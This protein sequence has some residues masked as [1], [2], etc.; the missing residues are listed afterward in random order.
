MKLSREKM[1]VER[2]FNVYL[3]TW[4]QDASYLVDLCRQSIVFD[5][6]AGITACLHSIAEDPE[7]EVSTPQLTFLLGLLC[8][9]NLVREITSGSSN[10]R[11]PWMFACSSKCPRIKILIKKKSNVSAL[12]HHHVYYLCRKFNTFGFISQV[13]RVKNRFDPSYDPDQSQG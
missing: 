9:F 2:E 11:V 3:F 5:D 6:L 7:V 8:V 4:C 10:L 13:V 12:I 1:T